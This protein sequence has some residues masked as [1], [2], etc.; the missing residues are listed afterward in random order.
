MGSNVDTSKFNF[1]KVKQLG[2][3]D[4][5]LGADLHKIQTN[6]VPQD[7]IDSEKILGSFVY[8]RYKNF[9]I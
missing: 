2:Y 3:D 1:K 5:I 7:Q 6:G 9:K 8:K 4:K